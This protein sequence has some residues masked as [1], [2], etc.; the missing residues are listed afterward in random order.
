MALVGLQIARLA[1]ARRARSAGS[2]LHARMVAVFIGVAAAP[3]VL[4]AILFFFVIQVGVNAWFTDQVG[5]L[6]EG[7]NEA[8]LAYEA[9]G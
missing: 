6:V 8:A 2:R 1:I 3:T 7:S 9:R 4:V 5:E